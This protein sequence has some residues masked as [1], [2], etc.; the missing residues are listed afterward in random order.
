MVLQG[1][2]SAFV[3][4]TDI[5][6]FADFTA[7]RA[8]AYERRIT[9]ALD[10]L[11]QVRVPTIAA[12]PGACVGGGLGIAAACDLRVAGPRARFG[13]PIART[14]GNCVA[15]GTL[16]LLVSKLG[17]SRVAGLLLTAELMAAQEAYACGFVHRLVDDPV[18]SAHELARQLQGQSPRAMAAA[19]QGL[20]RLRRRGGLPES[21]DLIRSTYGSQDFAAA[22]RSFLDHTEHTWTGR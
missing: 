4:G 5:N 6:E 21:E 3:A 11:Q 13:V 19:R 17:Q 2:G 14:L 8:V 18:D 16:E 20:F 12:I 9:A 7:D 10:S 22:V 15:M 1:A